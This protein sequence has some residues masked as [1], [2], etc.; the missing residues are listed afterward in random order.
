MAVEATADIRNVG[1]EQMLAVVSVAAIE[2]GDQVTVTGPGGTA[3]GCAVLDSERGP[4]GRW[5]TT[6][7][8]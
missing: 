3:Q 1:P 8:I 2:A 6:V 5:Y 4:D 7:A